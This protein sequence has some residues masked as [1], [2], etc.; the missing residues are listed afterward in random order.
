MG[1]WTGREMK[2][3]KGTGSAKKTRTS[4]FGSPGRVS[5]DSSRFYAGRLYGE[6]A[7]ECKGPYVENPLPHI[8]ANRILQTSSETMTELP[9]CCVHLMVTSPPYN[10]GKDYDEDL[11]LA[12]YREFLRR[13]WRETYRVL[14]SGGRACVNVANLGRR[15][16]VPLEAYLVQDMLEAGFLM[17]G[18][19]IWNKGPTASTSTAWGSWCSARNPVLRDVHEYVLVFSK[20]RFSRPNPAGRASTLAKE[21]FLEWTKSVWSIPAQSAK[22]VGHPAPF[23]VELPARLI[24]LLTFEGEVVLDPFMGSGQTALAALES[25]RRYVGYEINAQYVELAE[26]RIAEFRQRSC[27]AAKSKLTLC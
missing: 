12:E 5:H 14:V 15:P 18:Q 16:Y 3:T 23:P 2:M 17:R 6:A 13:V 10:V 25:G 11:T 7:A 1:S 8:V 21:E 27:A 24:R 20:E 9:D 19:I 4:A 26:R 22:A